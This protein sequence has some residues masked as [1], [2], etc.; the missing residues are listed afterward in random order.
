MPQQST[1]YKKITKRNARVHAHSRN[2][3]RNFYIS[4]ALKFSF[5]KR[6]NYKSRSRAP[7]VDDKRFHCKY[8]KRKLIATV[9]TIHLS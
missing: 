7:Y 4:T 5:P 8:R 1:R 3:H 9:T 2:I 6:L